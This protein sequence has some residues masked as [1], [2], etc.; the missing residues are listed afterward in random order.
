[1]K[2]QKPK[3]TADILPSESFKWQYIENVSKEV[4]DTYGFHEVRTP[5]FEDYELFQRGVG[6]TSDVVSKEMYDFYDKGDRHIALRPEGTASVVRAYVE[7]KLYGPEHNKPQKLYYIGPMFRYENPQGGRMRQFHQLG[8]EVFGSA[9][10]QTDV[11]VM[12]MAV[13]LFEKLGLQNLK[14]VINSLG[15][16]DS[17]KLYHQALVDYFQPHADQLSK[18]SQ[19]RLEKN[20]LRILDSKEKQDQQFVEGAPEILDYLDEDSKDHLEAVC[21][22]LDDLDIEY[23][24]DPTMV[25]GLDYYTDTVFEIMS[26]DKVFGNI[27]TICAGGRYD[28]LVSDMGGPETPA[29]GFALGLERVLLTLE[30]LGV[31]LPRP[32]S[33]D[34]YVVGIGGEN[35]RQAAFKIVQ[36]L[37]QAGLKADKDYLDRKP[38]AQFKSADRL[39][40]RSVMILGEEELEEGSVSIK[41]MTQGRQDKIALE[42]LERADFAHRFEDKLNQLTEENG[43]D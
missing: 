11:E 23:T 33:L 40:A 4:L 30:S 32:Q 42:D 36:Q 6:E 17:R 39:N 38:K 22:L 28:N 34:V 2:H 31:E 35:V 12:L 5:M 43:E 37:R 14:L 24:V 3:G 21:L 26:D 19:K 9:S 25:R 13:E 27:T 16:V 8:V 10:P 1:M 29:F 7:N 18:D 20:P 15:D 41:E